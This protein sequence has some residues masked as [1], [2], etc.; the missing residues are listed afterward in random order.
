MSKRK[1]NADKV[2]FWATLPGILTGI[3][4]IITAIGGLT[5]VLYNIGLFDNK[6]EPPSIKDNST[7][8]KNGATSNTSNKPSDCFEEFFSDTSNDRVSIL[9]AG[10]IDVQIVGPHQSKDDVA[11][12]KFMESNQPVG[13]MKLRFFTNN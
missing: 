13:A 2:S 11:G 9:E 12:V 6:P 7:S 10:A 8:N 5:V 4:A 3:A 1:K